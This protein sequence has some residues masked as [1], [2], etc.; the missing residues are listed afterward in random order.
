MKTFHQ[1]GGALCADS[2]IELRSIR[3]GEALAPT[4][5]SYATAHDRWGTKRDR[6]FEVLTKA[7]S[8]FGIVE[9]RQP[10]RA[11]ATAGDRRPPV[12]TMPEASPAQRTEHSD[13]KREIEQLL[14][15]GQI[16]L[17]VERLFAA[18]LS[19]GLA[20]TLANQ[21][22]APLR[23]VEPAMGSVSRL[24]RREREVAAHIA[25]GQTNRAIAHELFIARSTVE[26]H[27]ANIL[28]KLG[29]NS[30]TQ[31]A[32]WAATNGLSTS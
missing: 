26:R 15:A 1:A 5:V 20:A 13:L 19:A 22:P 24:T 25:G 3:N 16:E 6:R 27:V 4:V 18:I 21:R 29:F 10:R 11:A 30:R 7:E 28:N 8:D 2:M 17:A 31:I 9:L 14:A 12:L 32:A 23:I